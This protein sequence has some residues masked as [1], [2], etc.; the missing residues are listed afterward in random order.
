M[1]K[2]SIFLIIFVVLT[3][4]GLA[5]LYR[6]RTMPLRRGPS[7]GGLLPPL[8]FAVPVPALFLL[9]VMGSLSSCASAPPPPTVS[10][11]AW[12][13]FDTGGGPLGVVTFL[14]PPS[15]AVHRVDH[16]ANFSIPGEEC[17]LAT[18]SIAQA[19]VL[20]VPDLAA[21]VFFLAWFA[22]LLLAQTVLAAVYGTRTWGYAVGAVGGMALEVA[23]YVGR[24][25]MSANPFQQ[26]Q[27]LQ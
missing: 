19:Q 7:F 8:P 9:A 26:S 18:C 3:V 1:R 2:L 10:A 13:D 12:A 11:S 25:K 14:A 21:N 20:Y 15:T 27:F 23:G 16:P 24:V 22:L 17:T 4:A 5:A 6:L